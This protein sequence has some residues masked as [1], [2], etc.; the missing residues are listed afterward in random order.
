MQRRARSESTPLCGVR[1]RLFLV[2][3]RPPSSDDLR[4]EGLRR[5]PRS[6]RGL[7]LRHRAPGCWP[8][9]RRRRRGPRRRPQCRC[10]RGA[11]KGPWSA[12]SPGSSRRAPVGARKPPVRRWRSGCCRYPGAGVNA[13]QRQ[14]AR[15]GRGLAYELVAAGDTGAESRQLRR[16]D[17]PE[18]GFFD[19]QAGRPGMHHDT[20]IGLFYSEHVVGDEGGSEGD[21][22]GRERR[23]A[24]AGRSDERDHLSAQRYRAAVEETE[25]V[26]CRGKREHLREEQPLPARRR[27]GGQRGHDRAAVR[28]NQ[29]SPVVRSPD[30]E[31]ERVVAVD[32]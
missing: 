32:A 2:E 28:G 8:E 11:A 9:A 17:A 19:A 31:P 30:A 6:V 1:G 5:A 20:G 24:A 16:R 7:A 15:H 23:P 14:R 22:L 13:R 4:A 12:D 25:A 18:L 21:E 26:E 3:G 29:V 10:R 27:H